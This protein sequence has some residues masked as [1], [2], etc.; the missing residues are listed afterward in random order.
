MNTI[1]AIRND[2]GVSDFRSWLLAQSGRDDPVGD[3]A[4][5]LRRDI[6]AHRARWQPLPEP[7]SPHALRQ[8]LRAKGACPEA[9]AALKQASWEY[10]RERRAAA[11]ATHGAPLENAS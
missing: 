7:F 11:A 5:D 4:N 6:R 8:Y 9:L 1:S 3:L 2:Q 10:E